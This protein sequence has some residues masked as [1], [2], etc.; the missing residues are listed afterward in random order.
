[1][2]DTPLPGWPFEESPFHGSERAVQERLG[3]REKLEGRARLAIRNFM[4]EQHREFFPQLPFVIVGSLDHAGQPWASVLVGPP[5]F[6]TSPDPQHLDV[7]AQALFADPLREALAVN[8]SI[9]LLGIEP[10][11]RRRNRVNGTVEQLT[12]G[13]FTLRVSQSYGNCPKYIQARQSHF[14]ADAASTQE[15][16]TQRGNGLDNAM[17]K[18]V[19]AA[20]TFFIATA[21][22]GGDA[23]D[24]RRHGVDVSHRGGK[25]GFVRVDDAQTLTVPE[26]AGNNFF[27]TLG[28]IVANPRAGL[29]FVDFVT[30]DLLYLAVDAEIIWDGDEVTAFD[31][32]Q[33]L[34][35]L[36]I[37]HALRVE[38]A[39]PLRWSDPE[40]SP[41]LKQTGSWEDAARRLAD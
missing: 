7:Q 39:L 41:V 25:P 12:G 32:A 34:L 10:H 13:G 29:L 3:V 20:D 31:G 1:M 36:H 9:G 16:P 35:R 5:G 30:G 33:R 21:F 15:R 38:G 28:N 2:S 6:M 18:L 24:A 40:I 4:P 37:K 26:F 17:R 8:A 11:T 27:N 14:T 23:D 22:T 19:G